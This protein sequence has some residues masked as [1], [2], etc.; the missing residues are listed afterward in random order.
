MVSALTMPA[1]TVPAPTARVPDTT[2]AMRSPASM[3]LWAGGLLVA[4]TALG[5]WTS[6]AL[7]DTSGGGAGREAPARGSK[8]VEARDGSGDAAVSQDLSGIVRNWRHE[9]L[10]GIVLQL[11]GEGLPGGKRASISNA[12]GSFYFLDLDPGRYQLTVLGH[13]QTTRIID[14]HPGESREVEVVVPGR[15][16]LLW[17]GV[18][19]LDSYVPDRGI[20]LFGHDATGAV[21][22][23]SSSDEYGF[24]HQLLRPGDYQLVI[25]GPSLQTQAVRDGEFVWV[26]G[27]G[28]ESVRRPLD[29]GDPPSHRRFDIE[30]PAARIQALV[31]DVATGRPVPEARV[32]LFRDDENL[33]SLPVGSDGLVRFAELSPGLFRLRAAAPG[34]PKLWSRTVAVDS[35]RS[36]ESVALELAAGGVVLVE[37]VD[38]QGQVISWEPDYRACVRTLATGAEDFAQPLLAPA[39][40]RRFEH[41]GVGAC[42]LEIVDEVVA[43]ELRYGPLDPLRLPLTLEVG[44]ELSVQAVVHERA[45]VTLEAV[46]DV[47]ELLAMASVQV[48]ST[49]LPL[50]RIASLPRGLGLGQRAAAPASSRWEGWLAPGSYDVLAQLPDGELRERIVVRRKDVERQLRR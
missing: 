47:G 48:W 45:F 25:E 16:L 8:E 43:E 27:A 50:R 34:H 39:E 29:L 37:L 28:P 3:F 21:S 32:E 46:D 44:Q 38:A 41:V 17:G 35:N 40:V 4:V 2:M 26:S 36:T 33:G 15:T 1:P 18:L 42:E 22:Y 31:T 9:L 24:F 5:L 20:H 23:R 10:H 19:G 11:S 6:E 30:L 12:D 7:S 14:M 49:G 13:I